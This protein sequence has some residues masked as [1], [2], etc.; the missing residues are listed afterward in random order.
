MHFLRGRGRPSLPGQYILI[1]SSRSD[2][3][4]N[5]MCSWVGGDIGAPSISPDMLGGGSLS[6]NRIQYSGSVNWIRQN[7]KRNNWR[8]G[9]GRGMGLGSVKKNTIWK[10]LWLS[11]SYSFLPSLP[12]PYPYPCRTYYFSSPII[13]FIFKCSPFRHYSFSLPAMLSSF[14]LVS[15]TYTRY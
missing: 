12:I 7:Q 15:F 9:R 8:E 14:T 11:I 2:V 10:F 1:S 4:A 3:D 13:S 5:E 6:S